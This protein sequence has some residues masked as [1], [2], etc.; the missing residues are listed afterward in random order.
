MI[1]GPGGPSPW[2]LCSDV[3]VRGVRKFWKKKE[4]LIFGKFGGTQNFWK[5]MIFEKRDM[6][7]N[8]GYPEIPENHDNWNKWDIWKI[9]GYQGI[10]KS[11]QILKILTIWK[12]WK[13]VKNICIRTKKMGCGIVPGPCSHIDVHIRIHIKATFNIIFYQLGYP[14]T[15]QNIANMWGCIKFASKTM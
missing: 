12:T 9:R 3:V 14:K 11:W 6:C 1:A 13:S 2:S 10:W 4:Q 7:K 8:R 15:Q 5:I